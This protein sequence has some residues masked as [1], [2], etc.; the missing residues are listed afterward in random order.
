MAAFSLA[1]GIYDFVPDI[2][3]DSPYA[4]ERLAGIAID[5]DTGTL[6]LVLSNRFPRLSGWL[7]TESGDPV[8]GV[9]IRLSKADG[10]DIKNV[11]TGSD[12]AF[13]SGPLEPDYWDFTAQSGDSAYPFA[14]GVR[15]S[16]FD[17]LLDQVITVPDPATWTVQTI[18]T[19]GQPVAASVEASCSKHLYFPFDQNDYSLIR[20][21][22]SA[23]GPEATL[24]APTG[25]T[26]TV[27]ASAPDRAP[28]Q[29][30]VVISQGSRVTLSLAPRVQPS[31]TGW[32]RTE[33]GDPVAGVEIR[34][35]KADGQDIKNVTTGSDGAF[36]SGPLEPD[37]WDFTAQS[38][39]SAYPFAFGVRLSLFQDLLDQV[40]TVP[41]PAT[42]TVQTID[43]DGQ[44]VAAS[45]EASC[46]K[47]LYFPFD[48]NDYSLIR[49]LSSATGPEATL[50]APTG[51]TC[52]VQA[53]AP[54]RAP[55]QTQ[56]V[57][58]QGSR[59]TLSLAPRVQPSMTG[60][61]RTESGDPVAGV[62]IRLSKADGQ[63]IKNVTTGSDGAFSSGPLER[64]EWGFQAQSGDSAYPFVFGVQLSLFDDLLDQV[65]T[66]PDPATWTVQTIDTDGQPVAASVEASCSKHLYFPFDQN[67]YSLIRSL[68]SA[69]G[70]EATLV[71]PT[72]ATCTTQVKWDGRF[73]DQRTDVMAS[74]G[75]WTA[76]LVGQYA[77]WFAG[78]PTSTS[79][80][81]SVADLLESLAPNDGDG[82]HDLIPDG[83]QGYVTSL[84]I[85]GEGIGS[86]AGYLTLAAPVG[87]SLTNVSTMD[88]A[89]VGGAPA[90]VELPEGLASFIVGGIV[91]G[92]DQVIS[93]FT[94]AV[95]G[96]TGYA[97]YDP[98]TGWSM[99]PSDR[100]EIVKLDNG[101]RV[102][103]TLTDGGVGDADGAANG[104][105]DDPG[106][107]AVVKWTVSGF[108]QPV[109]MGGVFNLVKGGATVPL[110]FEVFAG[111]T[112]LTDVAVV[113][114]F[115][116]TP[117]A[118]PSGFLTVD[119]VEFTTTGGT[120]LRYDSKAGQFIQNWKTPKY[121]GA[122]YRV[123]MRTDVGT[124]ISADFKL[125]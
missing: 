112:E 101:Q 80:G 46:S 54:D 116:V 7:R 99:L 57:I 37:Y 105:I 34:L 74:G 48:Q 119:E 28:A 33:S 66:V 92:S 121:P 6:D 16:L 104:S 85:L 45:V 25:A 124:S 39:D 117:I 20:S 84:P 107:L 40:I 76:R 42:W 55:A 71:A 59:V 82:N 65:I 23:T 79:D 26:C 4:G 56:V 95:D 47:R 13:S 98:D 120:A 27:Q 125:K 50:V 87:S 122:C 62:E 110:K 24:V 89:D 97:K 41:D 19:D 63:D 90:G 91:P 106:G 94:E 78:T 12:G 44:P 75:Q 29:T 15:L 113:D 9:E 31:M 32:L 14:F 83:E 2:D 3:T 49:S 22:S 114:R 1:P 53:S 21:L 102:D 100:V 109:D 10:Q 43:T 69:T 118:C 73:A 11:T 61:L 64:G 96:I 67:D 60:W 77:Y 17:D 68:S 35:S 111:G 93:V 52:T 18:D 30:Q 58:S 86:T 88:P 72:G 115:T 51:A 123:T 108:H 38:G 70:P 81:D 36:S 5:D 103:I 8:A